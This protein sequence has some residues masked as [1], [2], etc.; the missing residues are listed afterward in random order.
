MTCL[1]SVVGLSPKLGWSARRNN[2]S[3][4]G[5]PMLMSAFIFFL[6]EWRRCVCRSCTSHL[7]RVK[8]ELLARLHETREDQHQPKKN[9]KHTGTP[10]KCNLMR[11]S[12]SQEG[13][14]K[15]RQGRL[16]PQNA[17]YFLSFRKCSKVQSNKGQ[18][19][20][21]SRRL[22]VLYRVLIGPDEPTFCPVSALAPP[23]RHG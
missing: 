16:I 10:T 4:L 12:E 8:K 1:C 5:E 11:I 19:S 20:P 9:H 14:K 17:Q 3:P 23:P 22:R 15:V 21:A 2:G 13:K 18:K 6:H 7:S